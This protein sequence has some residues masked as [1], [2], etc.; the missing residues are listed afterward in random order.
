M[1]HPAPGRTLKRCGNDYGSCFCQLP[2]L[3][4]IGA[5]TTDSRCRNHGK[6]MHHSGKTGGDGW[7]KIPF[8]KLSKKYVPCSFYEGVVKRTRNILYKSLEN[9]CFPPP[10]STHFLKRQLRI[11]AVY[12]FITLIIS[13][14]AQFFRIASKPLLTGHYLVMI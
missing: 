9:S 10:I 5:A 14:F 11:R 4:P 8:L 3:F 1:H 13:H 7:R 2:Q 12:R 6:R